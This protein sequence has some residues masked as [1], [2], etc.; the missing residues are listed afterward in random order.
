MNEP[1]QIVGLCLVHNEDRFLRDALRNALALCDR[2]IV[3]DHQS[4][5]RTAA[6]AREWAA[7]DARVEY[8]A[9]A[10]PPDSQD[11]LR[12]F[13]NT[14]TWIFGVDGDEVYDPAGLARLRETL[15]AGHYD[16]YR[17]V[18]GNVLHCTA[19]D[20]ETGVARGHLA[21]PS[22]SMTKLYNFAALRDWTGPNPERLHGGEPVFNPGYDATM[23]LR[24]HERTPWEESPFRCLHMVFLPR[25]SQDQVERVRLNIAEKNNLRGWARLRFKLL[26]ALG[27]EPD[28][29]Y[30]H[31][32]YRRGPEVERD[33]RA[34]FRE[35][36]P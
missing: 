35:G 5:D 23:D 31:E 1:A 6:I 7:R 4:T 22:R 26:R 15:R 33:V 2:L 13:L 32:K 8:V 36:I 9:L 10:S 17:Q 21:P 18:Y 12:P 28:S 24:L 30:K 14:R 27:R 34:F 3:A 20:A 29:T 19:L 11:L 16:A 25:S